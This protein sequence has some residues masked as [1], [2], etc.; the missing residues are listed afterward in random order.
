MTFAEKLKIFRSKKGISQT[1]LAE[2][3]GVH[4]RTIQNWESGK[5]LPQNL[6]HVSKVAKALE[7]DVDR[8]LSDSDTF[9]LKV[10]EE[11]GYRGKKE[12]ERILEDINGLFAGGEM[13]DEDIDELMFAIQEAYIET[14]KRNKKYT[15]KKYASKKKQ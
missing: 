2:R 1:E 10:S 14:K 5:R 9:V 8:L 4:Y 12:A 11:Y 7:T 15:P 6:A 13:A 3:S